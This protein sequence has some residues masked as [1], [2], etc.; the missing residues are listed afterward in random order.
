M[1]IQRKA[2]T[3]IQ[4]A[5]YSL[6]GKGQGACD[7]KKLKAAASTINL[8]FA[9]QYQMEKP[10][11]CTRKRWHEFLPV[12]F[13]ADDLIL[14]FQKQINI[15]DLRQIQS[16]SVEFQIENQCVIFYITLRDGET[17]LARHC[18]EKRP[19]GS[20]Y[21]IPGNISYTHNQTG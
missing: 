18:W 10:T 5:V 19:S 21:N 1:P 16:L 13:D 3:I 17:R 2:Q 7:E 9:E 4:I 20:G 8:K 11:E 15:Y 6:T 14:F 12:Y